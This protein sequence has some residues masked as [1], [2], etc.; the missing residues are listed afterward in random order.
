MLN[1]F[2]LIVVV[3]VSLILPTIMDGVERKIRARIHSR[4]GPPILQSWYDLLKL[5][6][7]EPYITPYSLHSIFLLILYLILQVFLL[8]Y[9][10][11]SIISPLSEYDLTILVALNIVAQAVFISIPLTIPNPFSIIGASRELMLVL[12]NEST[13]IIMALL[14]I[15]YTGLTWFGGKAFVS[16]PLAL[17]ILFTIFYVN[18]YVS[19]GR[20]PFDIAEAEPEI[21]SGLM[22]ELSGPLLA[23]FLYAVHLKRF[24]FKLFPTILLLMLFINDP[25]ILLLAS[26][27]L[28]IFLWI[29]YSTIASLLGRSRVDL[30]PITLLKFYLPLITLSIVGHVLGI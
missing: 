30:A 24:F 7:K 28:T 18:S 16:T 8:I 1:I 17:A 10:F 21:A 14:Y 12:V 29:I 2:V 22:I 13:F 11:T 3:V 5:L 15:Y 20:V 25:I 19:S 23:T 27:L 9:L 6:G 4:I 26:I